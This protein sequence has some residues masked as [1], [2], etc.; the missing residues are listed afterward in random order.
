MAAQ[1]GKVTQPHILVIDRDRH[2]AGVLMMRDR[3]S[4]EQAFDLLRSNAIPQRR[5]L[6]EVAKEV[7]GIKENSHSFKKLRDFPRPRKGDS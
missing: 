6:A 7:L 5:P 4:R 2:A 1:R 3:I